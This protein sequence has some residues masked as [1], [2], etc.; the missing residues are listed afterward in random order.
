[1]RQPFPPKSS[2]MKQLA[3]A[4]CVSLILGL[5]LASAQNKISFNRDVRPIL[6]NNCF[7]CHGFDENAR[8]ADLRLDT[9]DGALAELE[10]GEGFAIVP[11]KPDAS[12]LL[13]RITA[14]DE[15]ERMPPAETDKK[16][17]PAQIET[18]RKW[19]AQ[20]AE[21][22]RH[23]SFVAPRRQAVPKVKQID[24][25]RNLI[26]RFILARLEREGLKPSPAA[27][28]RTLIRR[29][30]LD[31]TGIPPTRAEIQRFLT[32]KSPDAYERMVD[33]YLA[34]PRYG[35]QM[36]R[37]WL[38]L[39]RY[40]DTSGYQYDR[41]R[42][43]WVWRDW[44]I[45]AYNTNKPF[46]KF[47]V[48]QLAGDLLPNAKPQQ[49]LATAFN[50]NHPI[51][52][53]GGVIDEEY[54]T[55]YVIDRLTTVGTVWM[56]LTLGC[57]RCHDHKY[58]PVS[59]KDFYQ[60]SAYFNQVPE[61]GLNGFAP[62]RRI[63]SPLAP[64]QSKETLAKIKS[65]SDE[66]ATLKMVADAREIEKWVKKIAAAKPSV[67]ETLDPVRMKS[68]GGSKLTK[69]A[70]RSILAGGANPQKDI[71]EIVAKT[72]RTNLT[73]IRLECLT[74][75]SLPGGGPGRHSNSNF[76]LSEFELTAVSI[77]DSG[78]K[79]RI[80]FVRAAADYSQAKY[81]IRKAIDGSVSNNNGWAVDGPTRKKPATAVFVASKPFGFDGGTELVFRL[82]H[83]AS[84]ATHGIGRARLSIT[85]AK[86]AELLLHGVP[87]EI[88][89]IAK[90]Q[91]ENRTTA[92]VKRL[93]SFVQSE[94]RQRAKSLEARLAVLDYRNSFPVT[95]I[96]QDM[97]KTRKTY[98]LRRGQYDQRGEVVSAG[99]LELLK[100]QSKSAP[101]NRLG[102]AQW[103]V[104]PGHPLTARVAVNRYWQQL[105]GT[106]IVKTVEDFG[107]Q[108]ELP[109]H[110]ALLDTLA[111]EFVRND[112]DVKQMLRMML[113]SATYR[114][115]SRITAALRER[116]PENRLLA[117]GPRFRLDAEQI[118]DQAL[119][120]SGLL[121]E[122]IGGP[123]VY[124]YQPKGLWLELN[125]RPG[126]SRAYIKG[127]G[128][129]LYRRSIYTFWK[130]T[131]LS[132][133]LKTFDAPGRES[134]IVRRSRTNTP[135]QAL[136]L[137]Q[138]PQFVEAA[139]K[140]AARMINEG[141]RDTKSRITFGFELAT[142]R[143]PNDQE[144]AVLTKF[145]KERL[146]F[147]QRNRNAAL[148]LLSVGDTPRDSR[149]NPAEH[150]AWMELARLLLNLDETITKG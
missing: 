105:F 146:E 138:G 51:T 41:E 120:T 1:M 95:M 47:T 42:T 43:M 123:S 18:I 8:E 56:G 34:S 129:A 102:L 124:P 5:P 89:N 90:K 111:I 6:A 149:L 150:A 84:F 59:Q 24:W 92:E 7:Q 29:V 136:L 108:G 53:E 106:G 58:D 15:D 44:V 115:S 54:R 16:L 78:K 97:K 65:L 113:T 103:I 147:Y 98:V 39:A 116:D 94:R 9:R 101:N 50:R 70:D 32:D 26:D 135:L 68:S 140:M 72:Q 93:T 133:M 52:I 69:Q 104:D 91:P 83:E 118:R 144:L 60:L 74:D 11:K 122:K 132:P 114:Q 22:E 117:R 3:T 145:L 148:K 121:K 76:V 112:W 131:V 12:I 86:S 119:A 17:T 37:H 126:L 128:E 141:G 134:C 35:E 139:R 100:Q 33:R 57:A 88:R 130:R 79:Q 85:S 61:R 49:I 87:A 75:S 10:S 125:N 62:Q 82:R 80:K 71:Y 38:D 40:A 13:T 63:V 48:E 21:Y 143:I 19:I 99:V 27:D 36:A 55:E 81:E 67:W 66:L 46:D 109:S 96:M 107:T 64:P 20:G 2:M 110:P 127:R 45:H 28:R 142:S 30:A 77:K 14:H 137:L 31:V 23:W 4:I 73:A 25:P